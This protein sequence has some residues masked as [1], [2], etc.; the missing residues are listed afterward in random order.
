MEPNGLMAVQYWTPDGFQWAHGGSILDSGWG[1][2]G[3]WQLNIRLPM[4]HVRSIL[5]SQWSPVGS[6]KLNIALQ[7]GLNGLMEAQ[8]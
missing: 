5:Y 6:W 8:Y 4:A 1:P 2:V 7:M 3:S